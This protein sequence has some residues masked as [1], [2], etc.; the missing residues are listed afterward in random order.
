M[1]VV[2][3]YVV[4]VLKR[5]KVSVTNGYTPEYSIVMGTTGVSI[6]EYN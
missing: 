1:Y 6:S 3:V 2:I 5:G 4:I